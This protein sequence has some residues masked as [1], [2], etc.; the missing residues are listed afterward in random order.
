MKTSSAENKFRVDKYGWGNNL[1]HQKDAC[2]EMFLKSFI[3]SNRKVKIKISDLVNFTDCTKDPNTQMFQI[4]Q[5]VPLEKNC[6]VF[7]F[8][9]VFDFKDSN[10]LLLDF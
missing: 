2:K 6:S 3:H 5:A 7:C 10:N 4:S 9:A 8:P 1:V